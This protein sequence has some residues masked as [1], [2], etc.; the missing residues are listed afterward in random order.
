MPRDLIIRL[1]T[2]TFNSKGTNNEKHPWFLS[3]CIEYSAETVLI[4]LKERTTITA[5]SHR[6]VLS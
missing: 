5:A 3:L 6:I 1:N 2:M 4:Q